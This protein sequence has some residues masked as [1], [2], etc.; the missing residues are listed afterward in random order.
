[1]GRRDTQ[2]STQPTASTCHTATAPTC[3]RPQR[4]LCRGCVDAVGEAGS[5]PAPRDQ[6][7]AQQQASSLVGESSG[8]PP[9]LR[10]NSREGAI[11]EVRQPAGEAGGGQ[12][13]AWRCTGGKMGAERGEGGIM[14]AVEWACRVQGMQL[15]E[16]PTRTSVHRKVVHLSGDQLTWGAVVAHDLWGARSEGVANGE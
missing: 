15:S 13:R 3:S 12:D 1:M 2:R 16:L 5:Q 7:Q 11:E 9:G 14:Q 4:P 6:Q 10:L 8:A